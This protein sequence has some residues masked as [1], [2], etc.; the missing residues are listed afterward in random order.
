MDDVCNLDGEFHET[1]T[2]PVE[3]RFKLTQD[4]VAGLM[5]SQSVLGAKTTIYQLEFPHLMLAIFICRCS[6]LIVLYF[7]NDLCITKTSFSS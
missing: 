1:F 7:Q 6:F 3:K 5:L 2:A 4:D